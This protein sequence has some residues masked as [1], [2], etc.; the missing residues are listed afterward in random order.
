MPIVRIALAGALNGK[1]VELPDKAFPASVW[2]Y[3]IVDRPLLFDLKVFKLL[4][5]RRHARRRR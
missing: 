3:A 5:V 4:N 1:P 2:H